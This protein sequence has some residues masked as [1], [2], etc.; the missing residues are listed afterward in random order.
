[1]HICQTLKFAENTGFTEKVGNKREDS[2]TQAQLRELKRAAKHDS[3][4]LKKEKVMKKKATVP[5][6]VVTPSKSPRRFI[7]KRNVVKKKIEDKYSSFTAGDAFSDYSGDSVSSDEEKS[8]PIE[9]MP[10]D[11]FGVLSS[12]D[13]FDSF[14]TTPPSPK[15]E[16][17][18]ADREK[19]RSY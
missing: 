6:A 9:H 15:K 12:D 11:M 13:E 5:T 4:L 1:M 2:Y 10:V 17:T 7:R 16:K 14:M 19:N 3:Y 8:L 18:L